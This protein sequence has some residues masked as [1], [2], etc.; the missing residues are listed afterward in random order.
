MNGSAKF[1]T[2]APSDLG[3]GVRSVGRGGLVAENGRV[4]GGVSNMGQSGLKHQMS[5]V[6]TESN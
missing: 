6:E 1:N 2:H 4:G 3:S 5:Y